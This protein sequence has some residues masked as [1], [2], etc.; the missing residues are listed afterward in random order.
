MRE[1][2][3]TEVNSISGAQGGEDYF[4]PNPLPNFDLQDFI[5]QNLAQEEIDTYV[6]NRAKGQQY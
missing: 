3:T 1:L 5:I 6:V 2:N 4:L